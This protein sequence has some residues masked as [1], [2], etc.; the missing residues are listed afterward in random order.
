MRHQRSVRTQ[1]FW[2]AVH[3][4]IR[5]SDW[6]RRTAPALL[7]TGTLLAGAAVWLTTTA[8]AS[9]WVW[10]G[11]ERLFGP[12]ATAGAHPA[13]LAQPDISPAGGY[14]ITAID[15]PSAG[16]SAIE[17]TVVFG[18]NAS[19]AMTG[20]YSDHAGVAHG[21]VYANGTF[22]SF[23]A[24]TETGL[25]P[26][27][28]WFQGTFGFGIDTAG[29]ATGMYIDAN[30]AE[31]GFLRTANGTITTLDD[32][33]AP[34]A[35]S[36]R[37]TSPLSINDNGQIAGFYTTGS[38]DTA[39]VYHG[40]LY[41]VASGAWTEI[42]EPNAGSGEFDNSNKEGTIPTAINA[43]GVVTGYYT[44]STGTN[45]GFMYSAG[46]YTS[47]DAPAAANTG[48]SGLSSGTVPA[49]IDAAGDV[50]GSYIDSSLVRHG[51]IRSASG[52]VTIL[53]APGAN[54]TSIKGSFGGGF[55]GTFATGIDPSGSYVSGMYTDSSGLEHGF[56][57]L[58]GSAT[59]TTFTPPGMTT[60]TTLP[61]QGVVLG[62]NASGAVVG[63]YLDSSEVA[64]GFE[65]TPTA[66]PTPTFNPVQG[67][68][69]SEQSVTISDTDSAATIYYTTDGSTPSLSS[70]RYT[71]PIDVSS[72]TTLN[73]IALDSSSGGYIESAVASATYMIEGPAPAPCV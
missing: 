9:H 43:S 4:A 53:D 42:D 44:D 17:G 49:S 63:S 33:N 5:I 27:A 11:W 29:D 34:T 70:T 19:G 22:A 48:H 12:A 28:G 50:T 39:S 52:T 68:Y 41:T 8:S 61:I 13:A 7:L 6:A 24:L 10:K 55:G 38:Y 67:T 30:N 3:A 47:F 37:G 21:F 54:T 25:S 16:T 58:T 18:V 32:P 73:A 26:Q 69:S 2:S 62:V 1:L 23:D 56:V 60:S 40:F 14:T 15:E 46:N 71:G 64:H 31:H 66:T 59:F 35:T 57:Y 36:S 65:Y 45:H 51:F 72:T 20:A